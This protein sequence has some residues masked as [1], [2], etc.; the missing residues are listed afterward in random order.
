MNKPVQSRGFTM[1]ELI[2]VIV[3]LGIISAVIAVIVK[4]PIDSYFDTVRRSDMVDAVDNAL[5]RMTR[6]VQTALPNSV[7]LPGTDKR[8]IQ[9]IPAL[10]GGRY[11]GELSSLG[12]GDPLS[13]TAADTSFDVL[14]GFGLPPATGTHHAVVYNLGFAGSDAY[15]GDTRAEIGSAT[16]SAI[17]LAGAGN[18]FPL[19]SPAKRFQVIP[20]YSV[21]YSCEGGTLT[22][23]TS[24]LSKLGACPSSGVEMIGSSVACSF[25]YLNAFFERNGLLISNIT[26]TRNGESIRAYR[27]NH[28][29]NVP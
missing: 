19:E 16:A 6:D 11:R 8:C 14:G 5:R 26:Y 13:F 2:I 17:T 1:V 22:R 23:S 4:A 27:E 21:V 3:V 15:A 12:T 24:T 28:V 20:D 9:L 10:G 29:N 18:K 25:D 7:H